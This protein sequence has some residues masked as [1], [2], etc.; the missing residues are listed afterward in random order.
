[1]EDPS[2]VAKTSRTCLAYHR[3]HSQ[4][5]ASAHR[6][7]HDS[8]QDMFDVARQRMIMVTHYPSEPSTA[9]KSLSRPEIS[10]SASL[11]HYPLMHT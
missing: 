4:S 2:A 7:L 6:L 10:S 9:K 11:I 3:A 5:A 1:M 8:M